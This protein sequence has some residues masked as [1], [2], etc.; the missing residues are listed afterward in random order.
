MSIEVTIQGGTSKKLLTGRKYCPDD[1]VVTAEGG[2]SSGGGVDTCNV[3]LNSFNEL[4]YISYTLFEDGKIVSHA[5][6]PSNGKNITLANVVCGSAITFYN[7]N[8]FNGF[9]H[10]HDSRCVGHYT[11]HMWVVSAPTTANVD[12]TITIYDDD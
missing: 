9:T 4:G 10:S 11:N 2:G 6:S 7:S 1:I 12:A 8:D 5:V 3:T